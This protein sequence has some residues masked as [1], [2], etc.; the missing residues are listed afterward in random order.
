[1]THQPTPAA[2]RRPVLALC[3]ASLALAA[4]APMPASQSAGEA[5]DAPAAAA[6][7]AVVAKRQISFVD[8]D[9]F[10]K[11]M[12]QALASGAEVEV[13]F[14]APMSPNAIAPRLGRWLNTVQE[15]G[16]EVSIKN[17][18][19]TRSLSLLTSLADVIYGAWKEMRHRG[20]VKDVKAEIEIAQNEIKRVSFKRKGA[21]A[22]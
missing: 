16:A 2:Q 7:A 21:A 18:S 1:M 9:S 13:S 3:L 22:A 10:D 12:E 14:A 8:L 6:S 15:Y 19:R 17:E 11:A 20:L 5:A 4:C